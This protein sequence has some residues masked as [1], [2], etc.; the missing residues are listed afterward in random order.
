[1]REIDVDKLW[2]LEAEAAVLGSMI[3]DSACIGRVLPILDTSFYKTEH[4]T[5]Y[6]ALIALFLGD[7]PTDAVALRTELKACNQLERVGGVGYISKIMNSVPSS[8]NAEYYAEVIR[9]RQKYRA[10]IDM[11][12]Q[13]D[14]VIDEPLTVDEQ[15]QRIQDIS[16]GLEQD[17]SIDYF[18]LAEHAEKVAEETDEQRAVI[19]TGFK[20]IDF[21]ID[22]VAAGELVILAG[23]PSRGKTALA[24]QFAVNMAKAGLSIIF[25]SLEMTY[26]ALIRRALKSEPAPELKK[27]DIVLHEGGQ[28]PEKQIA[29]IKTRKQTHRVDVVFIDYLQLMTTSRKSEN[30]NQ[31]ISTI[32]RKL[33]L[34]AVSESVPIIALSQLNRQVESRT[35]QRPRLSD[36]RESG[37][38]EQDADIVM[39]LSQEDNFRNDGFTEL[40]IAKNRYGPTGTARLVFLDEKV[41]FGDGSYD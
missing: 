9:D 14:R 4:Q 31:E 6:N 33:K 40:I 15:I 38:I 34:A 11:V 26:R 30:R 21:I 19:K 39:L 41:T 25:F 5:I 27:L 12:E 18:T 24:L 3:I 35:K 32:S 1:M 17:T 8:A 13:I 29:F 10:V 28:T 36:L 23:R 20:N 7:N 22:G 16:L 2:S 37:S